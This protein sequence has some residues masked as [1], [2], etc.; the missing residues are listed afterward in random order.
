MAHKVKDK[1]ELLKI[2]RK[3]Q[4]ERITNSIGIYHMG[5][6]YFIAELKPNKHTIVTVRDIPTWELRTKLI[7]NIKKGA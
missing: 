6:A 5:R 7:E 1:K 2:I 4:Y 3:A